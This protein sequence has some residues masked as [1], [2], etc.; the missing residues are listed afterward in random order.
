[1][2]FGQ[3]SGLKAK[4]FK[5]SLYMAGVGEEDKAEMM[6]ITSFPHGSMPF[7]YLEVPI[8]AERLKIV[9]FLD[10]LEGIKTS[11]RA[12]SQRT[13]SYARRVQLIKSVVQ[14]VE[15]FWL[16]ILPIPSAILNK[17]TSFCHSFLWRKNNSLVAWKKLILPLDE[18]GLG[19]RDLSSWNIILLSKLLWN[20]QLNKDTL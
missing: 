11:I 9:H 2:E 1:L 16:S 18:G 8:A 17:L 14:G 12:W 15:C 3:V 5:S 4:A 6:R 10:L 19:I 20:L 13:L 7:C